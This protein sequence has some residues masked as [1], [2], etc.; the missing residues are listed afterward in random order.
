M[1]ITGSLKIICLAF[2]LLSV[3]LQADELHIMYAQGFEPFSWSDP[4]PRGILIDFMDEILGR[5][6][7]IPIQHEICPWAR[8]QHMVANGQRDAIFTIPNAQR[9]AYA[10][11]SHL[12]LFSSEFV[13]FT[14]AKN[15]QLD[16]IRE[17]KSLAELKS[18]PELVNVSI[19]GGGWHGVNLE[20]V[21]QHTRV[22]S[23]TEIMKL[24]KHNR[25]D[26]YIEQAALV[27][28]QLKM[29]GMEQD[30]VEIP[31]VLDVTGWHLCIGKGS[32]LVGLMPAIDREL[33]L[34][35][36]DGSLER[37]RREIFSRY[38]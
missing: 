20:G 1:K 29:L 36:R 3:L 24:L 13:I 28:Y 16:E 15:P 17:I 14:G 9:R 18:R 25:A 7:N 34:M 19:I 21:K 6:L 22:V 5:R 30:I 23:S 10:E 12:P 8:C 38:R 35:Q 27:R 37:L 33:E 26:I 32:P 11:V 2:C 31:N 4:E